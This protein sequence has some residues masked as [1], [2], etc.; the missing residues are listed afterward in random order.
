[1]AYTLRHRG[2]GT[3]LGTAIANCCLRTLPPSSCASPS[4]SC[5]RSCS[6][7][8]PFSPPPQL[9][10]PPQPLPQLPPLPAKVVLLTNPITTLL[11]FLTSLGLRSR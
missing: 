7:R 5:R 3:G 2:S 4:S 1:M 6:P 8:S 9:L 10:P 11:Q